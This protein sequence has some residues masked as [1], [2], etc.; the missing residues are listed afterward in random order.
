[1]RSTLDPTYVDDESN[2]EQEVQGPLFLRRPRQISRTRH[3]ILRDYINRFGELKGRSV[4]ANS[5]KVNIADKNQTEDI[6]SW[7]SAVNMDFFSCLNFM[8]FCN[9]VFIKKISPTKITP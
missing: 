8:F 3:I 7:R 9:F 5:E 1:M 2:E 6:V 4:K